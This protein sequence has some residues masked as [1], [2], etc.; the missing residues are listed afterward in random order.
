[1]GPLRT[2]KKAR[3]KKS[4]FEER[5]KN[6]KSS[7][8]YGVLMIEEHQIKYYNMIF[9]RVREKRD[10]EA[11]KKNEE[12]E[13]FCKKHENFDPCPQIGCQRLDN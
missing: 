1:M 10:I 13:K 3:R 2:G 8:K 11:K 12:I 5:G 9:P 7:K 6:K 4:N